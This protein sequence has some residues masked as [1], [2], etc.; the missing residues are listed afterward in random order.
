MILTLTHPDYSGNGFYLAQYEELLKRLAAIDN[1]WRANPSQVAQ[2]WRIR[3][4]LTL[5][6]ENGGVAIRGTGSNDAVAVRLSDEAL[7]Q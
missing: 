2:W 6:E 7:A 1:A 5:L 4:E 3:S